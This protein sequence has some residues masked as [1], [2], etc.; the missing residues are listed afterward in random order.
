MGLESII[1]EFVRSTLQQ[2][3]ADLIQKYK[4]PPEPVQDERVT[5]KHAAKI[6]AIS[7]ITMAIWRT[8]GQGP[9]FEVLAT[10]TL[11]DGFDASMAVVGDELL[12]RGQK[13]LYCIGSD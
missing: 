6:L 9:E 8:K 5:T 1:G 13:H 2:E 11:D 10:N 3:L 12:L 4:L 7:P